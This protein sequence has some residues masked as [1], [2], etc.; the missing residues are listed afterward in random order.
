MKAIQKKVKLLFKM[1][2]GSSFWPPP[3]HFS[4]FF[5][6]LW[7][8]EIYVLNRNSTLLIVFFA[9]RSS[10]HIMSEPHW[11]IS[12]S[13][14]WYNDSKRLVSKC[15]KPDYEGIF[16]INCICFIVFVLC[17]LPQIYNIYR[18]LPPVTLVDWYS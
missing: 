10:P 4:Y 18:I 12:E 9:S 15:T 17:M 13:V 6:W 11:V 2:N 3:S 16:S 8:G 5:A 14:R 7:L 1:C